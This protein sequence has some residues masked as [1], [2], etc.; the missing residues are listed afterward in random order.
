LIIKNKKT[1]EDKA[2][3]AHCE[4]VAG[5]VDLWPTWMRG[6][7]REAREVREV[8]EAEPVEAVESKNRLRGVNGTR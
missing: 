2:F 1:D 8:R 3:W 7:A 4:A 5:E 6:E